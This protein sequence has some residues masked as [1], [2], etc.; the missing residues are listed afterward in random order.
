MFQW[1]KQGK[2]FD[3]RVHNG[4]PWLHEFAQAPAT[5]V[6]E[7]FVRVYFSCRPPPD[8]QGQYVSYTAFV[9]LDKYDLRRIQ[10]VSDAPILP[11]GERGTFDEFGVYPVSVVRDNDQLLAYYGGW[12]RCESVPFT[13][14]IGLARSRDGGV[15][16]QRLGQGPILN[17][18]VHEPF[19]ISGPKIRRFGGRW[20]L[21]YV[22]GTRW[23]RI[24]DRIEAVY[25]IRHATSDDGLNW[26]RDHYN[27]LPD[28]LEVDECQASP[29]VIYLNGQYHMFFCYK[30]GV[31]FRDNTRG[32]RIG[33]AYSDDLENW[34][35]DDKQAGIS[36]SQEGWDS[37]SVGYPH[38]FELDGK[39]HMLYTGNQFG[40]YGFG[41]ASASLSSDVA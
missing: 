22:A 37:E 8:D 19:V 5:L 7:D 27:L 3:P 21:W 11:L 38:V 23:Q 33:Y 1:I 26:H 20:H 40:K 30:Y 32:Y 12:T 31:N 28:V 18:D 24:G 36:M 15:N 39:L 29:D 35:R 10:R 2:I 41:L 17:S 9:D 14:A 25:K 13:V 16:F 6:F 34:V 4:R